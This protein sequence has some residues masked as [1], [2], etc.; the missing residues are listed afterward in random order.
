M[1][2]QID[3]WYAGGKTVVWSLLDSH[4]EVFSC[5]LHDYSFAGLFNSSN[6]DEWIKK[7]YSTELRQIL[8]RTEYYKFEKVYYDGVMPLHISSDTVLNV[9]YN[10]NFYEFDE[11]FHRSLHELE[12]WDI[13]TIVDTLYKNIY[14]VHTKN[15]KKYPMY[16]ASMSH[17]DSYP[18]YKNIPTIMPNMKTIV[19][20]RGLKNIIAT[21]SNRKERPRDLN[22]KQAFRVPF[23]RLIKSGEVEKICNFFDTHE[24]LQEQFPNHFL[25]VDFELLIKDTENTMRKV[26]KFLDIEYEDILSKPTRDGL[27]LE[28]DGMSYIGEENDDYTKLLTEEEISIIDKR[29]NVYKRFKKPYNI[30]SLKENIKYYGV[31]F[32]EKYLG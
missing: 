23:D 25:I 26:A 13:E 3:G 14:E 5:P 7:K 1:L 6:S 21:R 8:A 15:V 31:K 9:P 30:F 22:E 4:S 32:K 27:I 18:L 12:K 19:V 2:I 16:Y 29:V 20:K 28:K 10:T 11:K 17:A 24:K